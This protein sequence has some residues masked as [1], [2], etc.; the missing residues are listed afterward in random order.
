MTADCM[1]KAWEKKI[2]LKSVS[3]IKM[4][5]QGSGSNVKVMS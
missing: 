4:D 1:K 5:S 3:D 2:S